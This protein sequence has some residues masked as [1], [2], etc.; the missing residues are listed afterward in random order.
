M[1]N[2]NDSHS[3]D[4]T[5]SANPSY[6]EFLNEMS[7]IM[8]GTQIEKFLFER[9][10]P[11][12]YIPKTGEWWI[13]HWAGF[14]GE[15]VANMNKKLKRIHYEPIKWGNTILVDAAMF[16]QCLRDNPDTKE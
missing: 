7:L 14:W 16:W 3:S 4:C 15:T 10:T 8:Q 1:T 13:D 12:T 11:M 6:N 2:N 5:S 9:D